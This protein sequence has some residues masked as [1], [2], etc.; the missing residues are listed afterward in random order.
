MQ[1]SLQGTSDTPGRTRRRRVETTDGRDDPA[2]VVARAPCQSPVTVTA[3]VIAESIG[4]AQADM[5]ILRPDADA[6]RLDR[7]NSHATIIRPDD[8]GYQDEADALFRRAASFALNVYDRVQRIFDSAKEEDILGKSSDPRSARLGEAK[9]AKVCMD[10]ASIALRTYCLARGIALD[11]ASQHTT[12][13]TTINVN[14]PAIVG[15]VSQSDPMQDTITSL[16][17]TLPAEDRDRWISAIMPGVALPADDTS[18]HPSPAVVS[19]ETTAI[20]VGIPS[21]TDPSRD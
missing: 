21:D 19:I 10:T 11:A 14:G 2:A 18:R 17:A 8:P 3:R 12:N 13:K 4:L 1:N 9:I 6:S 7:P 5:G 16:L 20:P 15:T